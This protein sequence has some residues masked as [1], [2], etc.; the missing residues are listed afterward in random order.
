MKHGTRVKTGTGRYAETDR[1]FTLIEL[2][3]VIAIIAILAAMLLPALANAKEKAKRAK[4]LSNLHQIGIALAVYGQDNA[5]NLPRPYDPASGPGVGQDKAGSSLW[6]VPVL[7]TVA[8]EASGGKRK[9]LYCPGGFTSV[10]DD[11][12]WWYYHTTSPNIPEY[13]PTSY[14]WLFMR[15]DPNKPDRTKFLTNN[16]GFLRKYTVAFTNTVPLPDSVMVADVTMSQGSGTVNDTF[17]NM[18]T[19]NPQELPNGYNTSHLNSN[20]KPAGANLLFQ[21]NHVAWRNFRQLT[22]KYDWRGSPAG[23][24]EQYFWW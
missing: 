3:V 10:Q 20:K 9:V 22:C 14:L 12:F 13:R 6:D 5:D 19:S 11:D 21:D 18:G 8:L 16:M 24:G 1:G 17:V 23:G 15:N 7:T 4:C 2:L